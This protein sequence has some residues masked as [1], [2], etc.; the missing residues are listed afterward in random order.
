MKIPVP[1]SQPDGK[2]DIKNGYSTKLI[3]IKEMSCNKKHYGQVVLAMNEDLE[4][5]HLPRR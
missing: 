3:M 1:G 2:L 5:A 4:D